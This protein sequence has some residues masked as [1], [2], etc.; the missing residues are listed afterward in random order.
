MGQIGLD[1]LDE[2]SNYQFMETQA[3]IDWS[4]IDRAAQALGVSEAARRK[5]KQR[6][7]VPHRWRIALIQQTAGAVS[8]NDFV[9]PAPS[10]AEASQ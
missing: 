5:W 3:H 6:G 10:H 1:L 7:S 8:A 2:L 9:L 4:L